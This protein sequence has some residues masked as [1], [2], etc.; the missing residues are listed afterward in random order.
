MQST[1]IIMLKN[2]GKSYEGWCGVYKIICEGN[3]KTY[4]GSSVNIKERWQ[5][6]LALLR[7]NKHSSIYLQNSYNKYGEDSLKF[8]VLARLI[9]F[10]EEVLRDLEWYY[11]EKYQPAFNTITPL[12]CNKTQKWKNKISETTKKLYTE[13]GYINPRKGVG[14]RYNIYD[15]SFNIVKGNITIPEVATF[16]NKVSYHSLNN[17]IRKHRGVALTTNGYIISLNSLSL[18]ET[19]LIYTTENFGNKTS[20]TRKSINA[21]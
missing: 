13:R 5:Q 20:K 6:H 16:T 4:I 8:E 18:E 9:E 14:K 21:V 19:K 10:S 7:S 12:S 17:S 1:I 2:I 15:T 11:I 3:S